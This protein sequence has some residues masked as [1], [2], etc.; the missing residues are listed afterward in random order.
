MKAE[1]TIDWKDIPRYFQKYFSNRD[2][3]LAH[4]DL[5]PARMSV[6]T[7][8]FVRKEKSVS[9]DLL[10][11]LKLRLANKNFRCEFITSEDGKSTGCTYADSTPEITRDNLKLAAD[12]S[13]LQKLLA[14]WNESWVDDINKGR[15][16]ALGATHIGTNCCP[17][18]VFYMGVGEQQSIPPEFDIIAKDKA[19]AVVAR[20][21]GPQQLATS[22][23]SDAFSTAFENYL[24]R[25]EL[26][27]AFKDNQ[28]SF[29]PELVWRP[30]KTSGE[31]CVKAT[32]EDS[33]SG[34][35][36]NLSAD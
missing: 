31:E 18:V 9:I 30:G 2:G 20:N 16:R 10:P 13:T 35:S 4:T 22:R 34:V 17:M 12:V 3:T 15:I 29:V 19:Y 14:H 28:Y 1:V 5:A 24:D 6:I 11:I 25:I 26:R 23:W 36:V 33:D 32:A 8:A 7:N 27:A 21:S